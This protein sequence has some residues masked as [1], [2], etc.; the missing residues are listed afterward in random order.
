MDASSS[1]PVDEA[2]DKKSNGPYNTALNTLGRGTPGPVGNEYDTFRPFHHEQDDVVDRDGASKEDDVDGDHDERTLAVAAQVVSNEDV[3]MNLN[4]ANIETKIQQGV[5]T[6][7]KMQN[8]NV[9]VVDAVVAIKPSV[10]TDGTPTSTKHA[11]EVEQKMFG[12]TKRMWYWLLF[13]LLLLTGVVVG[14]IV[15]VQGSVDSVDL[16]NEILKGYEDRVHSK[17]P[18]AHSHA[19]WSGCQ[20]TLS[21]SLKAT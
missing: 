2:S 19:H 11:K 16:R 4:D 9:V 20:Q 1:F 3:E 8:Q 5:E 12:L 6:R 7:L 21:A 18:Q 13:V 17:T 10:G 15:P 14:F